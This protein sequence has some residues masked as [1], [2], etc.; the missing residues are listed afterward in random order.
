MVSVQR[1][2][3]ATVLTVYGIETYQQLLIVNHTTHLVATVLT[4]YGI[5]T[6]IQCCLILGLQVAT[7]LTVY[8]IDTRQFDRTQRIIFSCDSISVYSI[9]SCMLDLEYR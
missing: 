7:V 3:V 8:G 4:V 2:Y 1:L 5:E 9:E 6:Q